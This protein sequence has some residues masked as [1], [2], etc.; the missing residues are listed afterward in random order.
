MDVLSLELRAAGR[1]ARSRS[2]ERAARARVPAPPS[3]ASRRGAEDRARFTALCR[4]IADG[5]SHA[6]AHGRDW[7]R[8]DW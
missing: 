2:P 4:S 3:P 6:P 8:P 1:A 7:L 5:D